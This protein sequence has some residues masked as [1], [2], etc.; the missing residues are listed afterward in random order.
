MKELGVEGKYFIYLYMEGTEG[1]VQIIPRDKTHLILSYMQELYL[2]E[3]IYEAAGNGYGGFMEV[4]IVDSQTSYC[5]LYAHEW[6]IVNAI[7]Y[8]DKEEFLREA[9]GARQGK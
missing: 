2:C 1:Y 3:R 8:Q 5:S 7:P 9:D 6:K 4:S